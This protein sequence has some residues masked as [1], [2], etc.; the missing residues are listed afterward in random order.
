ML[1]KE[2]TYVNTIENLKSMWRRQ[3]AISSDDGQHWCYMDNNGVLHVVADSKIF[4]DGE[5]ITTETDINLTGYYTKVELQTS[6]NSEVN[7]FNI[8]NVP[9]TVPE[10][11]PHNETISGVGG[12]FAGTDLGTDPMPIQNVIDD[13]LYPLSISLIS[14]PVA[15]VREYG[16]TAPNV[17]LTATTTRNTDDISVV[18][19]YCSGVVIKSVIPPIHPEGGIQTYIDNTLLSVTKTY[20]A[21]VGDNTS[22]KN[23]NSITFTF[24]YPYYYGVGAPGLTGTQIAALTKL[25]A[26]VGNKTT[27]NSPTIQVYYFAYPSS[28]PVLTSILDTNGFET[29]SDYTIRTVSITG[30]DG[31][32]QSYRVYEFNNLTTQTSFTIQYKY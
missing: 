32:S 8:T 24:V 9:E 6:G 30:L 28:Y 12:I 11:I 14:D 13:M 26:V 18:N 2:S 22:T 31:T 15:S 16:N 3:R 21:L 10:Y 27:S 19:F 17:E 5:W 7:W 25:V 23:S 29:I 4:K 1:D 20:Y